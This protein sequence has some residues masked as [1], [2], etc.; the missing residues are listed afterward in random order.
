MNKN[1][2]QILFVCS[3]NVCRSPMAEAFLH[4]YLPKQLRNK[5]KV[6]SAGTLGL[7]GSLASEEAIQVMM[8]KDIDIRNHLSQGVTVQLLEDSDIIF[9]MAREHFE[10]LRNLFPHFHD[11][12]F[13]LRRYDTPRQ[14]KKE[15]SIQDPMG[16]S[17]EFY[18][19]TRDIIDREIKRILPRLVRLMETTLDHNNEPCV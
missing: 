2:F 1:K 5:V 6:M 11:K 17:I 3:G 18:R 7:V 14:E 8:E 15:E 10:F 13:F 9:V 16:F 19:K 12:I 4:T